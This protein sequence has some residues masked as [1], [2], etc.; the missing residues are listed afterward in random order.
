MTSW[1]QRGLIA[2]AVAFVAAGMLFVPRLGIEA[3]EAMVANGIYAH[4][5]P[6]YSWKLG[7]VEAPVMLISYLGALKTWFY[8]GVFLFAAPRPIVLRL[9]MLLFA[10]AS[11]WLFFELL[12]RTIGCRAAWIGTLLLATDTSYLLLNTADYGPVT[13]QFVFKL[14][15]LVLLVR[16][17]QNANRKDL[18]WAFFLFGLGMWDKAIFA[19]VLFGLAT[20]GVAVFPRELRKHLGGTN[21]AVAGLAMLAGALPLVIYNIARPLET[22]R[23]NAHM[24]QTELPHKTDIL[25]E[26]MDGY[27]MFG[28]LT[29]VEPGP[30]PGEPKH[31]YQSLSLAASRW[32][33]HPHRNAM[34]VAAIASVLA[35]PFLWRWLGNRQARQPIL[36]GL[37]ACAATWLPMVLTAGAGGA[38][39]HV[40][41]LWPFHLI[42]VAAMLAAIP[43]APAAFVTV[44]LCGSN[45]AVTNQYYADLIRN[46]PTVRWTDAMDPLER[47][48]ADLH[49]RQ[50]V[51][52]DW[53]FM[54]TM[55]LS[56]EGELPMAYAD[57]SSDQALDSQLRDPLNVFVAH[58]PGLAFQPA[59][60]AALE[61]T[62]RRENYQEEPLTTIH[63]RN[64]RPTFDVFRFRK[65]HL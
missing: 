8:K 54:E 25:E 27:V 23:S 58:S 14:A 51:A 15:A 21:L 59:E 19:W 18:A 55:N 24:G 26:T 56:S 32:T 64:G 44:L 34:L 42:P 4:G 52:A 43:L 29:A 16:F 6:W 53:G 33:G 50:I 28:F 9:P 31:W 40:I 2:V 20:A 12:N 60:R 13:L 3:D 49:P 38:A 5:A 30:Q 17:H 10:A 61:D 46:G 37:I 48:L 57:T 39:H 1:T 45:L 47:Y 36:F 35:L 11:L 63:D 7:D 22:L 62:A 65:L 41:L